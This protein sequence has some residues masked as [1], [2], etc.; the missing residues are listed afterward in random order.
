MDRVKSWYFHNLDWERRHPKFMIC[1]RMS[2]VTLAIVMIYRA[3]RTILE[4]LG[5]EAAVPIF[6]F[7]GVGFISIASLFFLLY[8]KLKKT[9][10]QEWE[11]ANEKSVNE[12]RGDTIRSC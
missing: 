1:L 6:V 3:N 8:R 7:L 12:E 9:W 4:L 10:V 2:V 5:L 11:L